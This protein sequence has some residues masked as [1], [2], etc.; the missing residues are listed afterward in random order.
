[1]TDIP[2]TVNPAD[3]ASWSDEVDV[4][5]TSGLLAKEGVDAPATIEPRG[6]PGR[7]E[8][9]EDLDDVGRLR[10]GGRAGLDHAPQPSAPSSRPSR[11]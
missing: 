4:L 2:Q 6:D 7:V 9:V 11:W 3:V 5:V 1:M 10:V 8:G